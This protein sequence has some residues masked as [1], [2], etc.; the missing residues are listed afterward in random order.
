MNSQDGY[1]SR[2]PDWI[3]IAALLLL[4]LVKGWFAYTIVGDNG[5]PSWDYRPISDV[6][7]SSSYAIYP[8][9]PYPQHVMGEKGE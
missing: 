7:A 5:Q 2:I 3:V 8:P 1:K 4:I 6:P 9:L